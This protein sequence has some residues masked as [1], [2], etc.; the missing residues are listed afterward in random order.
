MKLRLA[1]KQG[2]KSF[3]MN[4]RSP[5]TALSLEQKLAELESILRKSGA[6]KPAATAEDGVFVGTWEPKD[7]E[8][9]GLGKIFN[10]FAA[11]QDLGGTEKYV[12]AVKHVAQLKN[13]NGFDGA[14][15]ATDQELYKAIENGSYN[16][17]W[18]IPT[19]DL[20]SGKA[21][22]GNK[23]Q[24]GS[25]L[26]AFDKGVL[27]GIK[28]SLGSGSGYPGW[29]WSSTEIRDDSS[30]VHVVRFSDGLEG[31][32][33]KD[34]SRLSCRPVRLVPVSVPSLG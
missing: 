19:R 5:N 11:P 18:I 16:G 4:N 34:T 26:D 30:Y 28:T 7:S 32:G 17:S 22:G 3:T 2:F 24:S 25:L 33:R 15:Y 27:K 13:W 12:D 8:G 31:W 10:V 6:P 21:V 29:Y 1:F 20:L 9:K 14:N 23:T